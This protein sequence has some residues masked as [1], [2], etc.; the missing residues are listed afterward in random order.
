MTVDVEAAPSAAPKAEAVTPKLKIEKPSF[1]E[2]KHRENDKAIGKVKEDESKPKTEDPAPSKDDKADANKKGEEQEDTSTS[3]EAKEKEAST[4]EPAADKEKAS[5]RKPDAE[6]RIQ[7]LSRENSEL[8]KQ[9]EE[10]KKPKAQADKPKE[11]T[12]PNVDDFATVEEYQKSVETYQDDMTKYRVQ[13]ALAADRAKTEKESRDKQIAEQNKKIQDNWTER[14]EAAKKQHAD[15]EEVALSNE[16]AAKIPQGS[17][18][19]AYI[20]NREAGP[21]LL[22]HLGKNPDVLSKLIQLPPIDMAFEL[23]KLE[24]SIKG[25][26][27]PAPKKIS[28]APK[29]PREVNSAKTDQPDPIAQATANKDFR[30]F[31][32]KT[33]AKDIARRKA[34]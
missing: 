13:E 30:T 32:A 15:F 17:I 9:L 10:A 21:E 22:Y 14:V 11:P 20:L 2:F 27:A 8:Q 12:R 29:P 33:D 6:A 25:E 5:R 16:L 19:D 23:S 3:R 7:Q 24:L 31:K 1:L 18:T 28:D 4:Q 34:G 26:L